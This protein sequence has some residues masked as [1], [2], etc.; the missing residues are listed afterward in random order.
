[1][2]GDIASVIFAT[3][4]ILLVA[5]EKRCHTL[6]SGKAYAAAAS[7]ITSPCNAAANALLSSLLRC[8][9]AFAIFLA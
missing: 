9:A 8:Q 5:R 2:P 3:T 6:N 4:F 1:L 7:K